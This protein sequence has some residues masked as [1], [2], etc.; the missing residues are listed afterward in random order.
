M[1]GVSLHDRP[2]VGKHYLIVDEVK[3]VVIKPHQSRRLGN[4]KLKLI[5]IPKNFFL[6]FIHGLPALDHLWMHL[7]LHASNFSWPQIHL[8]LHQQTPK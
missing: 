2:L 4:P 8:Q 3:Y 1:G 6:T 5:I 7:I